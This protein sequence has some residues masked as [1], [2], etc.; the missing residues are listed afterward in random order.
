MNSKLLIF[1]SKNFNNSINEVKEYLNFSLSFSDFKTRTYLIDS[2]ISAIIVDSQALDL[3]NLSEINKIHN[4]PILLL[5]TLVN[6][7]KLNYNDKI[8]LPTSL[9][10]LTNRIT[11][12]ITAFKFSNNSALKINKYILDK[13]EKKLI[14][15]NNYISITEREVQLIELLFNEKKPLTKNFILK[16]I[17]N[18]SDN[19]DTHT[20]ETHVYRLRKKIYNKFND[21][22][23]ILNLDKGY[24]I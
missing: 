19:A 12:I 15:E 5:E 4:K 13:N 21:E 11:N 22:K 9:D 10:D 16:K 24:I 23:F 20:V 6:N 8:L 7:K 2:S 1:G 14:K 3:V 17:W 18:Y